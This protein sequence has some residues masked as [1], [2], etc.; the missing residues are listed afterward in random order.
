MKHTEVPGLQRTGTFDRARR[1]RSLTPTVA[2]IYAADGNRSGGSGAAL[3]CSVAAFVIE[4]SEVLSLRTRKSKIINSLIK[5]LRSME[6]R[7]DATK[8]LLRNSCDFSSN[9][10]IIVFIVSKVQNGSM[11]LSLL[12]CC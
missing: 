10:N 5:D 11:L 2:D 4:S 9:D 7:D 8:I 12:R 1:I 6:R 3:F